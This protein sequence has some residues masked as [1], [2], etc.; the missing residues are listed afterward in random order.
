MKGLSQNIDP[1]EFLKGIHNDRREFLSRI[2]Q[3]KEGELKKNLD[4]KE[5]LKNIKEEKQQAYHVIIEERV[6]KTEDGLKQRQEAR[7]QAQ[8]EYQQYLQDSSKKTPIFKIIQNRYDDRKKLINLENEKRLSD[9]HEMH[10]PHDKNEFSEHILKFNNQL[11]VE[12]VKRKE[13]SEIYMK[14]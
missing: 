1:V 12:E 8:L 5:K 4:Q 2:K 7:K 10:K 9:L 13:K 11:I 14:E 3:L 6:G